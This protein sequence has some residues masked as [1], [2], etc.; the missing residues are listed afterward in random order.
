MSVS[1]TLVPLH[2]VARFR[3]VSSDI[4]GPQEAA[5]VTVADAAVSAAIG[6]PGV[7]RI[8]AVTA[9]R[10]RIGASVTNATGGEHWPA[11][12]VEMIRLNATDK[13]AVDALS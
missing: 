6:T 3:G 13:I 2:G 10:V 11:G 12:H 9:C 5:A 7:Y 8:A 1:A 4:R